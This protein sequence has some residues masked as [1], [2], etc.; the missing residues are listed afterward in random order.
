MPSTPSA[1]GWFAGQGHRPIAIHPY[2]VG[3]Y[4]REQVYDHWEEETGRELSAFFDRWITG[5][6]T[7]RPGV[8]QG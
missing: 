4:K 8:P 3:M 1:V 6:R 2:K 5:D 7:P